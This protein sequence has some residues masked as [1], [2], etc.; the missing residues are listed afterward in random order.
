MPL[1]PLLADIIRYFHFL[2]D[3]GRCCHDLEQILDA[4][5]AGPGAPVASTG[6]KEHTGRP[7][8]VLGA[9]MKN[10]A[11]GVLDTGRPKRVLGVWSNYWTPGANTG[12]PE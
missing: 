9:W 8:S 5:G 7:K 1:D 10:R 6:C 11:P 3:G 4:Q 12:R 2:G